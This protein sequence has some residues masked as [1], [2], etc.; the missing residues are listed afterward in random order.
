MYSTFLC[1]NFISTMAIF[2]PIGFFFL[3]STAVLK[4]ILIWVYKFCGPEIHRI[5]YFLFYETY[6]SS[7][8]ILPVLIWR[9]ISSIKDESFAS[10][11]RRS[12][13]CSNQIGKDRLV[14]P[15][16]KHWRASSQ[17]D[18]SSFIFTIAAVKFGSLE[19]GAFPSSLDEFFGHWPFI[20]E[21]SSVK[22]LLSVI[23]T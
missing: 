7:T 18:T 4:P 17:G 22:R 11:D 12:R 3:Y 16:S 5:L 15:R 8:K 1:Y 10:F 9:Q 21:S 14:A 6:L 19:F 2:E 23:M 20:F 13:Y